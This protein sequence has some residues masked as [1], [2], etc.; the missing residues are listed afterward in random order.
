MR[1]L[2]VLS[3]IIIMQSCNFQLAPSA[4][5]DMQTKVQAGMQQTDLLYQSIAQSDAK[6]YATF[7]PAYNE[8][9]GSIAEIIASD[10]NRKHGENLVTMATNIQVAFLKY[11]SEHR[12][13]GSI[14]AGE[15]AIYEQQMDGYWTP[16]LNAEMHL[17]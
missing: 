16:L 1:K 17:R 2:F 12:T 11:E 13:K 6:D 15:A 7:E 4:S 8:I 9:V 10:K 5:I 3:L 14:T